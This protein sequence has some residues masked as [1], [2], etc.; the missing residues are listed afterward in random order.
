MSQVLLTLGAEQLYA[1]PAIGV[2]EFLLYSA[3]QVLPETGKT[4]AGF[5]FGGLAE[6]GSATASAGIK[7]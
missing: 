5:E 2:Q 1:L 4:S 3:A 7:S 6:Q